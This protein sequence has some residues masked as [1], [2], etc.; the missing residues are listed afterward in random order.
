ME[1]KV[2]ILIPKK[3][4]AFGLVILAAAIVMYYI[5]PI[6]SYVLFAYLVFY[7]LFLWIGYTRPMTQHMD[8]YGL[9]TMEKD[10]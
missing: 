1:N 4:Y 3:G 10:L 7:G 8:V 9:P 2:I 6:I 5:E